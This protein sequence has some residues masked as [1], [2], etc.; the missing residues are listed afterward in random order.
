MSPLTPVLHLVGSGAAAY[1]M[2]SR[3]R[4]PKTRPDL[5][6]GFQ[7]AESG[8]VPFL[9]KL[10]DRAEAE[11]DAWLTER[12]TIHAN[13]ERRHGQI[14]ANALKQMG[15]EVIDVKPGAN[16]AEDKADKPKSSEKRGPFLENFYRGYSREDLKPERIEWPLFF[17]STYILEFDAC[18]DFHHMAQAL[19]GLPDMDS[20]RAGIESV[21]K[22]EAR[23]AA[24]LKEAMVRRYG[25]AYTVDMIDE[26]RSR[27][28]DALMA[29]VSSFIQKGDEMR[30][31]AKDRSQA[32]TQG[33]N[34]GQPR[35]LIQERA[36]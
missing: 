34:Q 15:K 23:H 35:A 28:V 27:K 13:D 32:Q 17:G 8:A 7:L 24:Y 25:Y 16:S 5:L 12:L 30:S 29:M 4:D 21:A 6:A 3:I 11:G 10:R 33:Q 36:A 19:R 31:L 20:A 9:T 1:L 14:F 26:W 18:K 2:A 22:D